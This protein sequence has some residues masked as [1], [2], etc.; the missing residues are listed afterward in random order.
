[1]DRPRAVLTRQEP[2]A[3]QRLHVRLNMA[4]HIRFRLSKTRRDLGR[5]ALCHMEQLQAPHLPF[6]GFKI[7]NAEGRGIVST[8]VG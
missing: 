7:R 1:M 2:D 3:Q 6:L 5:A 4:L 8:K